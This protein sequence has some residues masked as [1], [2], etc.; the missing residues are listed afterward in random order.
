MFLLK[1]HFV[2][3]FLFEIFNTMLEL[4][5]FI[6]SCSFS[7]PSVALLN[8]LEGMPYNKEVERDIHV[9]E[10]EIGG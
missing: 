9:I 1:V 7:P 10:V 4:F 8:N 5:Y 3:D 2:H 6:C